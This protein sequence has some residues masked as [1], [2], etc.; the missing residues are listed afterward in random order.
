[1]QYPLHQFFIE[2]RLA[3]RQPP[4]SL[5][6]S[7]REVILLFLLVGNNPTR[8]FAGLFDAQ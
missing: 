6:P 7:P 1:M 2:K 8:L 4:L 3:Y 5:I